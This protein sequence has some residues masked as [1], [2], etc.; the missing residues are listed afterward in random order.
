[1]LYIVLTF[2]F[3]S[4]VKIPLAPRTS[5]VKMA[6]SSSRLPQGPCPCPLLMKPA[7]PWRDSL[8]IPDIPRPGADVVWTPTQSCSAPA[9]W[10]YCNW[11]SSQRCWR[12]RKA[13]GF[14]LIMFPKLL[15]FPAL[16][17]VSLNS[18]FFFF[19]FFLWSHCLSFL[20]C[21]II[22]LVIYSSLSQC[23]SSASM[24]FLFISVSF[25][26][27]YP[28]N[29][30]ISPAF[31]ASVSTVTSFLWHPVQVQLAQYCLTLYPVPFF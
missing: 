29:T 26:P 11:L 4:S 28:P 23:F 30:L 1:M 22:H 24:T 21:S 18:F 12:C 3:S 19:F 15:A 5:P 20:S 6:I 13:C 10:F 16:L 25:F 17:I 9:P 7:R 27:Y 2:C 14:A 31:L 8:A